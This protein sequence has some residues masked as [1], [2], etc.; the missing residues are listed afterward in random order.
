MSDD[1]KTDAVPDPPR[2]VIEEP[3][4]AASLPP[5]PSI[6]EEKQESV[7][8]A[9][10]NSVLEDQKTPVN[11]AKQEGVKNE[12]SFLRAPQNPTCKT[13]KKTS[14]KP[15]IKL[16]KSRKPVQSPE[17]T[18]VTNTFHISNSSNIQIGPRINVTLDKNSSGTKQQEYVPKETRTIRALRG[19]TDTA[20]LEHVRVVHQHVGERWRE[21]IYQMLRQWLQ[22]KGSEATVGDLTNALW[23]SSEYSAVE[24]LKEWAKARES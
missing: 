19:S 15:G 12:K 20:T 10:K 6:D 7:R 13:K 14:P 9:D 5:E 8:N 17:P 3:E 21:V 4:E 24:K 11:G 22:L 16:N 2:A 1:L 18:A 23:T